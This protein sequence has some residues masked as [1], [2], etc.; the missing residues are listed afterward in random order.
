MKKVEILHELQ[1]VTQTQNE[2]MLGKLAPIYLLDSGL[3]QTFKL[4]EKKKQTHN[5]CEVQ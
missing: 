3:P 2:Q 1:N 5:I 4:L